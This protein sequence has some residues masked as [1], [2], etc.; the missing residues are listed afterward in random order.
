MKDTNT[1]NSTTTHL[2]VI[3][4]NLDRLEDDSVT[5]LFQLDFDNVH[6]ELYLNSKQCIHAAAFEA[7]VDNPQTIT[8]RTELCW[9]ENV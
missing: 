9:N 6:G 2:I 3:R 1:L 4:Y 7:L 5:F 8:A